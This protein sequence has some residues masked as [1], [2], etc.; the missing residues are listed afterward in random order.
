MNQAPTQTTGDT[1]L[2][3]DLA[4]G[5]TGVL[6]GDP[7]QVVSERLCELGFV[8]GTQIKVVRR[9]LLGDPVEVELRGYRIC[10]RQADLSG[11]RVVRGEQNPK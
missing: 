10:L 7:T 3:T 9:G 6:E 8:A 4:V 1:L 5:Q 11:L 2:L